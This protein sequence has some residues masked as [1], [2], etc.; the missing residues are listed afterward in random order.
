[1]T[2]FIN[3]FLR[4]FLVVL[5]I[6]GLISLWEQVRSGGLFQRFT[7]SEE[8]NHTV[9]LQEITELGKLELVRYRFKDVIEHEQIRQWFPNPKAVLIVEGEAVGCIDLTK[10]TEQDLASDGDSLIV[11]LPE[12]EICSYKINHENSKVYNTENAF[13]EEAGLVNEA[14]RQA[15]AQIR[16][17]ALQSGIL[18]ETRQNADKILRPVLEKVSGKKVFLTTRMKAT[19]QPLR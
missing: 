10:I 18:E 8:V 9:V 16:K 6:V 14:Y 15:E 19:F 3:A 12:P 17:S 4:L 11:Y 13:F 1:M 7:K 5:L 2:R